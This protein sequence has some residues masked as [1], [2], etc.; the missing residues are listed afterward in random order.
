MVE[1]LACLTKTQE[2]ALKANFERWLRSAQGRE[3]LLVVGYLG[4]DPSYFYSELWC[5]ILNAVT[6]EEVDYEAMM[7]MLNDTQYLSYVPCR[8]PQGPG[9]AHITASEDTRDY[10]VRVDHRGFEYREYYADPI[11]RKKSE[12]R[13]III[14]KFV[15]GVFEGLSEDELADEIVDALAAA[16]LLGKVTADV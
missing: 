2:N 5:M 13:D 7:E 11:W 4:F 16:E 14:E 15:D 9:M 3:R 10:R 12:A 6:L 1:T 8:G